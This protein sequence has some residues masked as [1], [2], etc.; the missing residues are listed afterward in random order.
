[1]TTDHRGAPLTEGSHVVAWI[2]GERFTATVKT[3]GDYQNGDGDFRRL[4]LVRDDNGTEVPS[5][6]DGVNVID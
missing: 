3:I 2:F 5:F 6:S 4:V 1:M